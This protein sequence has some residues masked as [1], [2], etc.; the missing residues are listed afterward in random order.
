[1]II[2]TQINT[3]EQEA[4]VPEPQEVPEQE[5][6]I[7]E[8]PELIQTPSTSRT[9]F[10]DSISCL[11]PD[12][13]YFGPYPTS[14][15]AENL[16]SEGFNYI[17]K[18]NEDSDLNRMPN[19]YHRDPPIDHNELP[20]SITVIHYP[21]V[22]KS[23]PTDVFDYCKFIYKIVDRINM[24]PGIKIYVHCRAG[25]GRSSTIC[26]SLMC[27][28]YSYTVKDAI[29][30]VVNSCLARTTIKSSKYYRILTKEQ[31]IFVNKL[32]KN[33]YISEQDPYYGWL[34]FSDLPKNPSMYYI[35]LYKKLK[36]NM[37]SLRY[38]YM[39]KFICTKT[40]LAS[41]DYESNHE[42][43]GKLPSVYIDTL[44]ILR[45]DLFTENYKV[46]IN[47]II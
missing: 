27:T 35:W 15:L 24:Q 37:N 45:C 38:T 23:V 44:N 17:I 47:K 29:T 14:A 19:K 31:Y 41:Q 3:P 25:R 10:Y 13:L 2:D 11:I 7:L 5:A 4:E 42:I 20:A 40:Q 30:I 12:M 6:V 39:R 33:I 32:H 43:T 22:D 9:N 26:V 46:K 28:L 34:Y 8:P 16:V 1:M 36:D 18:L 21:I